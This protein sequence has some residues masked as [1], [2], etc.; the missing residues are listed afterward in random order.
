[1]A[2]LLATRTACVSK[3][4]G[5]FRFKD[6][7]LGIRQIEQDPSFAA[8]ESTG[9]A[10]GIGV[11][12]NTG[13]LLLNTDGTLA[14]GVAIAPTG[15]GGTALSGDGAITIAAGAVYYIT[16]AS[17]AALTLAAPTAA[18]EGLV[19]YVRSKSKF[20]HTITVTAGFGGGGA[21]F[22]VATFAA[23][24]GA[25]MALQAVNAEWWIINQVGITLA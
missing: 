4:E 6:L 5:L 20:A 25:G 1:M 22:D 8:T 7:H 21:S 16:K 23:Y 11:N 9:Q 13:A 18:Q 12:T 14:R 19:M 10:A 15:A 24:T 17:A 3:G 2:L